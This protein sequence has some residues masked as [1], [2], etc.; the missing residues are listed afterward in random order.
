MVEGAKEAVSPE[1]LYSVGCTALHTNI[2]LLV[3]WDRAEGR[4][5][6]GWRPEGVRAEHRGT[7]LGRGGA[8]KDRG[9]GSAGA[10]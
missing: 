9:R 6:A 8:G 10:E 2:D 7:S 1:Y 5:R 4:V 3:G